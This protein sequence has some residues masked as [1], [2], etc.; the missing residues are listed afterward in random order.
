MRG[1]GRAPRRA[2]GARAPP[3]PPGGRAFR[4]RRARSRGRRQVARRHST[5]SSPD[6]TRRCVTLGRFA[7]SRRSSPRDAGP[8]R[9]G[10][11]G[12]GAERLEASIASTCSSGMVS[13]RSSSSS[14]I[15]RPK[16]ARAPSRLEGL[17]VPQRVDAR[18]R[19]H[20]V[21]DVGCDGRGGLAVVAEE[22]A[23]RLVGDVRPPLAVD[24]RSGPPASRRAARRA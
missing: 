13:R 16:R 1:S 17:E 24:R 23:D 12:A 6:W 19:Q 4:R 21:G 11:A 9:A 2:P 22:V 7:T 5:S 20:R 8:R 3:R 18:Q 10:A 15:R 14:E